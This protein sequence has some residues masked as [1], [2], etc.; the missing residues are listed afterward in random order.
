MKIDDIKFFSDSRIV[1]G[2]INNTKK[3]FLV[4]V[5]N[6]IAHIHSLSSPTQWYYI[7]SEMNPADVSTRGILPNEMEKC[8]WLSNIENLEIVP[9]NEQFPLVSP[10]EDKEIRCN[11]T[12]IET[13]TAVGLDNELLTRFSKWNKLVAVVAKVYGF[14]QNCRNPK[15]KLSDVQLL[16]NAETVI[17]RDIQKKFYLEEIGNIRDSKP[18]S[19]NSSIQKLDPYIDSGRILRVGGRLKKYNDD[20][21]FKNPIILPAKHHVTTLIVR[22]LHEDV[23]H[24]GRHITEGHIRSSGFWIVG[25]KRLISSV[26]HKCVTCRKLRKKP[27]HQ[28]MSD[29]PED[30]L[31][32]GQPPFSSVGVDIF[33]PWNII[34]RR[35]RGG[36]ANSKRWAAL[37][38]CLTTRAVH[39]EVVEEMTSSSFINALRRFIAIRGPV[40]VLRSDRGTNFIGAAK[41]LKVNV[42]NV[43]EEHLHT[44]LNE[45]RTTW[46]FNPSHS[47]HMGGV[48]ERMIGTTR[49]ILDAILLDYGS[50]SLTHEVLT[51]FLAEASSIINSRPLVPVSTDPENPLVLSPSTLLTQKTG[52]KDVIFADHE[53]KNELLQTQWRRVQHLASIFWK[54]WKTEYL[55]TLQMRRKWNSHQRNLSPDDVVLICDKE[56]SRNSWPMGIVTKALPSDDEL[57]RKVTVRV[58]VNGEPKNYVRPITELIVILEQ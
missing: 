32:P 11:K 51:T 19:R 53:N 57:V 9:S 23:R 1:L 42:I 18:V 29:L 14:I 41:E 5:A 35:T 40:Q 10:E 38:T 8:V 2:Y 45:Q 15:S 3:R 36:A 28:K 24:Q 43:E 6:R 26:L 12:D 44:F 7:R 25:G 46:I 54:R 13:K 47:S 48:W 22:K 50:R 4:Y 33:G 30:R 52:N 16:H 56:L 31:I 49:R 37:F 21:L 39:I 27:E 58:I 55:N 17:I 34:T 20:P